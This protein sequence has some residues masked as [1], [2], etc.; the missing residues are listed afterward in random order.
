ML[1]HRR[2]TPSIRFTATHLYTWLERGTVR[3]T[4]FGQKHN[5]MS[6]SR[7]E[8]APLDPEARALTIKPQRFPPSLFLGRDHITPRNY[9][10]VHRRIRDITLNTYYGRG[11]HSN[12]AN[13]KES[14]VTNRRRIPHS[15]GHGCLCSRDKRCCS[16]GSKP[17]ARQLHLL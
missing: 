2:F 15:Y 12:E 17:V 7:L 6:P 11:F 1:K 14:S 5:T 16:S 3:I 4:R 9:G 8:P 13:S 10:G